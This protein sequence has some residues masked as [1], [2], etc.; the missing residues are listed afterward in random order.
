[1][2]D[3]WKYPTNIPPEGERIL[4]SDGLFM[5]MANYVISENHQIWLF[6]NPNFKNM[7]IDYWQSLPPLPPR[8]EVISAEI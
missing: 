1:M 4:V 2:I 8:I 6:D 5:A 7:K 3:N